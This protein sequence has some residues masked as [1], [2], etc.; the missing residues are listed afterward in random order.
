MYVF[1]LC[2][3][4]PRRVA[5]WK[6]VLL[7]GWS[8]LPPSLLVGCVGA[9]LVLL[10]QSIGAPIVLVFINVFFIWFIAFAVKLLRWQP[11]AAVG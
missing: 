1:P 4:S 7:V 6:Y 11:R 2:H 10:G 5:W 8:V 9:P 3:L